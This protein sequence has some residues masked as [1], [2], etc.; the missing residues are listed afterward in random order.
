MSCQEQIFISL[1][2]PAVCPIEA[3][4]EGMQGCETCYTTPSSPEVKNVCEALPPC[5]P[6]HNVVLRHNNDYFYVFSITTYL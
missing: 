6:L 2:R 5:S 3:L 1:S 4:T